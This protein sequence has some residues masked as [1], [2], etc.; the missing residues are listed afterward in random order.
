MN[1]KQSLREIVE[2]AKDEEF[3]GGVYRK[4]CWIGDTGHEGRNNP[5]WVDS[6]NLV[7]PRIGNHHCT[8][9]AHR[10]VIDGLPQRCVG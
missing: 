6:K 2:I 5:V 8:I 1:V 7:T 3:A 10:E 4:C 9:T